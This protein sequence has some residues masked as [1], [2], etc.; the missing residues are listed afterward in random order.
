MSFT[1]LDNQ[2]LADVV[3]FLK[4]AKRFYVMAYVLSLYLV[5]TV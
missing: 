3:H 5:L 1:I 2:E 4:I